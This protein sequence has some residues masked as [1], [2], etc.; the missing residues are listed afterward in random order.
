M[1]LSLLMS[2][3]VE[4]WTPSGLTGGWASH[5]VGLDKRPHAMK[6][7]PPSRSRSF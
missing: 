7:H 4:N 2:F 1:G 3:T 5:E 6:G